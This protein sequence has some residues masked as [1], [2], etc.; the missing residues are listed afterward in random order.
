M[1]AARNVTVEKLRRKYY[2]V[3]VLVS[4]SQPNQALKHK[5]SVECGFRLKWNNYSATALHHLKDKFCYLPRRNG[6]TSAA[7]L[8]LFYIKTFTLK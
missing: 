7:Y 1:A 3:A 6:H 4:K 2:V 5:I 8:L